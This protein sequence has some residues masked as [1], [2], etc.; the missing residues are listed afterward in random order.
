MK[1]SSERDEPVH[2]IEFPPGWPEFTAARE[3]GLARAVGYA[4]TPQPPVVVRLVGP[5]SAPRRRAPRR[6]DS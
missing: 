3:R 4:P 6:W 5:P 2:W 1:D